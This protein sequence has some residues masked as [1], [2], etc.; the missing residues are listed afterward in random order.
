[1]STP[2]GPSTRTLN[3]VEDVEWIAKSGGTLEEAAER[4]GRRPASVATALRRAGR[5]DLLDM[6]Q[7]ARPGWR[8]YLTPEAQDGTRRPCRQ[9]A[10]VA[11]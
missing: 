3:L 6:L 2:P 11:A 9:R 7:A 4:T 1:M 10:R 8:D 5:E